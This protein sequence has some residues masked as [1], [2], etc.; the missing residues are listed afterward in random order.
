[1]LISSCAPALVLV[2]LTGS[3]SAAPATSALLSPLS[4]THRVVVCL[5]VVRSRG[6]RPRGWVMVTITRAGS[7]TNTCLPGGLGVL[8]R[9]EGGG[10]FPAGCFGEAG[11]LLGFGGLLDDGEG[12]GFGDGRRRG[13]R[14]FGGWG[15]GGLGEGDVMKVLQHWLPM[16]AVGLSHTATSHACWQGCQTCVSCAC[17]PT[18]LVLLSNRLV[19]RHGLSM[20]AIQDHPRTTLCLLNGACMHSAWTSMEHSHMHGTCME[21]L[22]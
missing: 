18:Y 17:Y 19:G 9:F 16:S 8:L 7:T 14:G 15:E 2:M 11:D 4:A 5:R 6:G 1:M 20:N 3:V 21:T 13:D 22:L 10:L 12:L